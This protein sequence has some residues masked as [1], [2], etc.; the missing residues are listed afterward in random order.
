MAGNQLPA[1]IDSILLAAPLTMF[2]RLVTLGHTE[3]S[4]MLSSASPPR[5]REITNPVV[6]SRSFSLGERGL[7]I[8]EAFVG[9]AAAFPVYTHPV[10]PPELLLTR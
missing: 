4:P 9:K 7:G 1:T 8:A 10:P 6:S 2:L 5:M 3:R